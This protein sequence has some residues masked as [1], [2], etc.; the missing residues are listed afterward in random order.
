[1]KI[2]M[3]TREYHKHGGI[4]KVVAEVSER[5]AKL[6]HE[7]HVYT[8][9]W[10]VTENYNIKF[11]KVPIFDIGLLDKLGLKKLNKLVKGISFLIFSRFINCSGYDIVHI[12]GDS[13]LKADVVTAHSC[14]KE[15]LRISKQVAKTPGEWAM[16]NL[17]PHHWRILFTEKTNYKEGNYKR[18]VALTSQIKKEI[19]EHYDVP[20]ENIVIIPNGINLEEFSPKNR[21]IYF[22]EIRQKFNI[23][24]N[25]IVLLFVGYEFKRKGL[26]YVIEALGLLNRE[27]VKLLIVGDDNIIPYFKLAKR[28]GVFEKIIFVGRQKEINK[29]Y[30]ASDIFVFPTMYEAFPLVVIEA[31]ASGLPVITT[32]AAGVNEFIKNAEEGFLLDNYYDSELLAYYISILVNDES[33]RKRV[34][35]KARKTAESFS[36][37]IIA[38]KYSQIYQ[39]IISEK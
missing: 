12:H 32:K 15:W 24:F 6:G 22:E 10:I 35:E 14:H 39:Q 21:E 28:L 37:D 34:G 17:N 29:F 1:M 2:A 31:M 27:K 30:A 8:S 20:E 19:V 3:V 36:W 23:S 25:D 18:I 7:V 38:E 11:H 26:R 33:L 13:L 5:L 16:K 9:K 4:S